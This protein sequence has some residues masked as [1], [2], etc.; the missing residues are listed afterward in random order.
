MTTHSI[1]L[2]ALRRGP[3]DLDAIDLG[4]VDPLD[5]TGSQRFKAAHDAGSY[6]GRSSMKRFSSAVSI[7]TLRPKRL[8]AMWPK[9]KKAEI[10]QAEILLILKAE[11][12][13]HNF[14]ATGSRKLLPIELPTH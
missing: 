4:D 11:N 3:I 1:V 8:A 6:E 10:F 9:E 14:M 13:S 5:P 2:A 12:S 7:F